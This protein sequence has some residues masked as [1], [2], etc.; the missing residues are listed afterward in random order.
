M[1]IPLDLV[2]MPLIDLYRPMV[3]LGHLSQTSL[4]PPSRWGAACHML[5]VVQPSPVVQSPLLAPHLAFLPLP[6]PLVLGHGWCPLY[7]SG[8]PRGAGLVA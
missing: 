7:Y 5:A 4:V 1:A 2:L 6:C 8:S 3:G